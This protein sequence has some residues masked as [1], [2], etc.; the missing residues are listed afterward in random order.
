MVPEVLEARMVP[1]VLEVRMVPEV[2]EALMVPEVSA[3][4][5]G[6]VCFVVGYIMRFYDML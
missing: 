5:E 6:L 4:P 3:T 2:L 1:E